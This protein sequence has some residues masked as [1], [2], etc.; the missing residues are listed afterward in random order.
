MPTLGATQNEIRGFL[1]VN[2]RR[3]R[4]NLEDYELAKAINADLHNV[5]GTISLRLGRTKLFT[6]ALADLK[7]RR[8]SRINGFRYQVAGR[9][10]YRN[11]T[12]ILT[13]LSGFLSTTLAAYRP[14]ADATIWALIADGSAMYKDDGTN[15]RNW[16]I[17]APTATPAVAIG[18]AG[19]LSG[20]YM[21]KFTYVRKSGTTIAC[22]SNPSPSSAA[23]SSLTSD[24][25]SITGLTA[26]SDPPRQSR[27]RSTAR[28]G[29]R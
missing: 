3:N 7:L 13:T 1:G 6:T 4:L 16:G 23:S 25:L 21:V 14:L 12:S 17:V 15:I 24:V 10:L 28:S 27:C 5:L 26:S 22:E 11:N 9:T 18:A 8:L 29:S 20:V 19:S 2:L